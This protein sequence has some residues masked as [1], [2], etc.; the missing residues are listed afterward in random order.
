LLT[1]L[2]LKKE[3]KK[4][5]QKMISITEEL[6]ERLKQ[7]PNASLLIQNLLNT[8][9]EIRQINNLQEIEK[10]RKF[11]LNKASNEKAK[12]DIETD[13]QLAELNKKEMVLLNKQEEQNKQ[14][15]ISQE[16]IKQELA[17]SMLTFFDIQP[18]EINGL[19]ED[20]YINKSFYKNIFKYLESK[21]YH[22]KGGQP[23]ED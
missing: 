15:L 11:I 7:E 10:E 13:K 12:I 19:V 6:Q 9:Y 8:H 4:M 5:V 16:I 20:F 22:N 21:G 14:Q 2:L 18:G 3:F 1:V 17:D 23:K